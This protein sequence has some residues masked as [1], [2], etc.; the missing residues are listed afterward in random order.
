[1]L[2]GDTSLVTNFTVLGC[3]RHHTC[4][5]YLHTCV[6]KTRSLPG[7][8]PVPCGWPVASGHGAK[9][10]KDRLEPLLSVQLG[11]ACGVSFR[12]QRDIFEDA[13]RWNT[14]C[15]N[16]EGGLAS[17]LR[18]R[19]V[20]QFTLDLRTSQPLLAVLASKTLWA[21]IANC[22]HLSANHAQLNLRNLARQSLHL[23][24]LNAFL[25]VGS[26]CSQVHKL[27]AP[28]SSE[29]KMELASWL[30]EFASGQTL[31]PG[32]LHILNQIQAEFFEL[33]ERDS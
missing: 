15:W 25:A 1:M 28:L 24:A 12:V 31:I 6:L 27:C 16:G 18:G 9:R 8:L 4:P 22:P 32:P 20:W 33:A 26:F 19:G 13:M 30:G 23:V 14:L 10:E 29:R 3:P 2:P 7:C 11:I 21:E 17:G 5:C